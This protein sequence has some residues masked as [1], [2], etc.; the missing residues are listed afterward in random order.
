MLQA[1]VL[2]STVYHP[3]NV[4]AKYNLMSSALHSTFT[5][6]RIST[7][8]RWPPIRSQSIAV[9]SMVTTIPLQELQFEHT[10][11]ASLPVDENRKRQVRSEIPGVCFSLVD[12]Q[13]LEGPEVVCTSQSALDLLGVHADETDPGIAQILSLSTTFSN[14]KSY[15]HCYCGHQFGAFAGMLSACAG[16]CCMYCSQA[17]RYDAWAWKAEPRSLTT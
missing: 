17:A 2:W 11:L 4:A 15:A 6:A 10:A 9:S 8:S 13:P 16:P 5:Y 1:F 7:A 3:L 12:V 14:S